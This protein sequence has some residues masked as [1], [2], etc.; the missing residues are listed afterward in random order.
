MSVSYSDIGEFKRL[1]LSVASNSLSD[2]QARYLAANSVVKRAQW[3]Y[4]WIG[5]W[6]GWEGGVARVALSL[7]LVSTP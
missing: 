3:Q 6:V 2:M 5:E 7:S 1:H 4:R